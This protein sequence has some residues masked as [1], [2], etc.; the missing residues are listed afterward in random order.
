MIPKDIKVIRSSEL[1]SSGTRSELLLH[2]CKQVGGSVYLS[3]KSG[4]DYL[5]T[6]VFEQN[7]MKLEFHSFQPVQYEQLWGEFIPNLSVIDYLL[8]CGSSNFKELMRK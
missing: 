3:G 5:D 2:L 7:N 4:R 6:K 8:N 1:D